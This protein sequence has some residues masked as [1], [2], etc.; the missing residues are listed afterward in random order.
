MK[1]RNQRS[2]PDFVAG[3]LLLAL[4]LF[5]VE[6][7]ADNHDFLWL[8]TAG[9]SGAEVSRQMVVDDAGS[10]Y[11]IGAFDFTNLHFGNIILTNTQ[12]A[13]V[14]TWDGF[15]VK[16]DTSGN[17]VWAKK[18]GGTNDD[19]GSGIAVDAQH[20]CY[21]T[22][23]FDSSN[24]YIDGVT[25]TNSSPAGNSS[26]FVAK[27]DPSA[28]LQWARGLNGTY[29][30]NDMKITVDSVGNYYLTGNFS[31]T[32][33][34]G[35]TN[36]VSRGPSNVLLLK[37]DPAGNLLWAQSAGGTDRDGGAGIGLDATNNVYILANI[38]S[39]N[40]A[41]GSFVFSVYGA[42]TC[43]NLV[44]AKYDPAGN[45][46]WA[47]QC[48]GTRI[49]AGTGIAVDK[50][51]YCYITGNTGSTN[52]F[53]GS[54]TLTNNYNP[55]PLTAIFVARLGHSG[56]VLWANAAQGDNSVASSGIAV[57][58]FGDCYIA[59]YFQS[60]NLVFRPDYF[61]TTI[62]TNSESGFS[63]WADAFVAKFDV[64]GQLLRAVQPRGVN[65]QRAYSIALDP[66]A[67]I[68]ITGWTQGTNVLFGSFAATNAYLDMFVAKI[69]PDF[70][71]LQIESGESSV[72][73]IPGMMVIS[74]PINQ[75][76]S[77]GA[78]LEF[79][80]NLVTW[81]PPDVYVMSLVSADRY[82]HLVFEKTGERNFFRL[83][84]S[85]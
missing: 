7:K 80:T 39:T 63:T 14:H 9:G 58:Q 8:R 22:G 38:R 47:R 11:I 31:G 19:R 77:A 59:G 30:H 68:Y 36:L 57:N 78:N 45:V 82:Y 50:T 67:N 71:L 34:F 79:S 20:N 64:Y 55:L 44:V 49:D 73:N 29:N 54:I 65:D 33:T 15:I 46:I 56:N 83:R 5:P 16:Y 12:P 70:P 41:F 62:L 74:W 10:S 28:N 85:E 52:L 81:C 48:G 23:W 13:S 27:F 72:F 17:V 32:N 25:L 61:G 76:G 6:T 51:G 4:G 1:G 84:L 18:F 60:S 75:T 40:A 37:Y 24:F 35:N 53:F 21:V 26:L 42:D 66:A 2:S 43:Q 69:D 3:L